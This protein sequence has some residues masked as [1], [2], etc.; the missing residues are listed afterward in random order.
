MTAEDTQRDQQLSDQ[1]AGYPN[2]GVPALDLPSK[3]TTGE[4]PA[5]SDEARPQEGSDD[6][7]SPQDPTT[8]PA[9]ERPT[10][11]GEDYSV[12]TVPQKRMLI[13][14][15][16]LAAFFSP[17]TGSIYYPATNAIAADL[18]VSPS[19]INL[20]V[21]TYLVSPAGVMLIK[22]TC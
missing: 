16:S 12:F 7:K 2:G 11:S 9:S 21:T 4:V 15:A 22:T 5:W 8:E 6:A 14:T 13:L 17:M 20:T 3:E 19:A 1:Q 18:H 10:P